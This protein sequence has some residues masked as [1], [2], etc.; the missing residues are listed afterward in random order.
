MNRSMLA[1][2]NNRKSTPGLRGKTR[3]NVLTHPL[4]SPTTEEAAANPKPL[5]QRNTPQVSAK[6]LQTSSV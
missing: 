4:P 5:P 6:Q 3:A 2:L 1:L